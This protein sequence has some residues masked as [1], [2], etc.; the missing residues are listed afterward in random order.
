MKETEMNNF[1]KVILRYEESRQSVQAL[2]SKRSLLISQCENVD[3]ISDPHGVGE[4]SVGALC[5]VS[6]HSELMTI[7]SENYGEGYSYEEI[8]SNMHSEGEVC[9][10]CNESYQIKT[11]PLAAAKKELGEAKRA[12]SRAGKVLIS[13]ENSKPRKQINE[14]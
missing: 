6:V 7:V 8:L 13:E 10:A 9:E 2:K 4:I 14:T 1:Q 5:L 12:L 3:S 11:G